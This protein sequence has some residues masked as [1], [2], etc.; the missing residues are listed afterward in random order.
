[1]ATR[2]R[3]TRKSRRQKVS[4]GVRGFAEARKSHIELLSDIRTH[5]VNQGV[6]HE[7]T[8]SAHM[9]H[10]SE[11]TKDSMCPRHLY[12]KIQEVPPSDQKPPNYY[13]LEMM[14]AA[15]TA[16]HEKWQRWLRE[17]GDLWGTWT[18]LVCEAE[19]TN[20]LKPDECSSCG[21][22]LFRYD[23]V[24]LEDDI[25]LLVGH[26]DGAVPRLNTLVEIKTFSTGSVRVE[27]PDL[28]RKHTYKVDGK[29]VIDHDGVWKSIK[30]PLRGHLVQGVF[31]LWLCQRMGLPFEKIT[32]IYENKT[33]QDTKT[34]EVTLSERVI[35]PYL[36]IMQGVLDAATEEVPPERPALFDP[37]SAPCKD[38]VFRTTCWEG[39]SDDTSEESP[40]VPA[41]GS[42]TRSEATGR[43][44]ALY[45]ASSSGAED[46]GGTRGH[47]GTGRSRTDAD[48]DPA[49][50]VGRAPRRAT[51]D[52]GGGRAVVARSGGEGAGSRFARRGQVRDR[53]EGEGVR[54]RFVRRR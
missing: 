31:Y 4:R 15:G 14:W 54:S 33:N 43:E 12:Y 38:C 6:K 42:R 9:V 46:P 50:P 3:T 45:A 35:K 48:D 40:A 32:F 52:G 7:A 47:R 29:T 41:G 16:E 53:E 28:V 20:V 21:K 19:Y 11:L 23:E 24:S 17:M 44:A 51:G 2:K 34:F 8:R 37:T 36:E 1:M 13:R 22:D 27:Q 10:I 5:V 25:Y 18:C 39:S 26:A 30:R 49:D